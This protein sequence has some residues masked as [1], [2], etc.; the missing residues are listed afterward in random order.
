MLASGV[1][2]AAF[3]VD[4]LKDFFTFLV[5]VASFSF[6]SFLMTF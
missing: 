6:H 2:E 4:F 5:I 3:V 1:G